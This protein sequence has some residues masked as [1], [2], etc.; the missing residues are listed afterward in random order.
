MRKLLAFLFC[1]G[2]AMSTPVFAASDLGIAS[3]IHVSHPSAGI[4]GF[5]L[6]GTL[7]LANYD[8]MDDR[9]I[10]FDLFAGFNINEALSVELGWVNFG[11]VEKIE[12]AFEASA[13]HVAVLGSLSLQSDLNLYGKL[14]MTS[15]DADISEGVTS[16]NDSGADVFF[17]AGID[18]QVGVNSSV[19][20]SAD[21]YS[22]GDEDVAVYSIG[23]KQRF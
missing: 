20:F 17:G 8:T 11:E 9:D 18:Y 13:F 21:W 7:G 4:Q 6:G 19:R 15:W 14:G 23:A 10:A 3:D 16:V 2:V 1:G 22:L 12:S 5:Y